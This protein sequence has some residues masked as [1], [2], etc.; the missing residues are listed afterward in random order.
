MVFVGVAGKVGTLQ[1]A[2]LNR[3]NAM[4]TVRQL[5]NDQGS[6]AGPQQ[7]TVTFKKVADIDVVPGSPLLF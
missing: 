1:A 5:Q 6:P 4:L 7:L 2:T 3:L